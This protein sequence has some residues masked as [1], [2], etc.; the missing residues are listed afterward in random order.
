MQLSQGT[1]FTSAGAKWCNRKPEGL[2]N[3]YNIPIKYIESE[4][5][6]GLRL[7]LSKYNYVSVF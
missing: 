6:K 5:E 4:L 1:T 3:W 7:I 2:D